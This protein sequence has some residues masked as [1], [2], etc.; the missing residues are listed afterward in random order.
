[1][2]KSTLFGTLCLTVS[3]LATG[4]YAGAETSK[5]AAASYV[6]LGDKMAQ[7][8]DFVRAIGAYNIAL[9]FVPS[10]APAY[11]MF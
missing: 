8:G 1:M 6:E 5:E 10:F 3:V 9:Q 4:T 7:Q 2:A 11:F